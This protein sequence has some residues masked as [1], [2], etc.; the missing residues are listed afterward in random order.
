MARP[1][2]GGAAAF[3]VGN[4]GSGTLQISNG[5]QVSSTSTAGVSFSGGGTATVTTGGLW[6]SS[7]AFYV[8]DS[9]NLGVCN[10]TTGGS[11]TVTGVAISYIG[12]TATSNGTLT[13]DGSSGGSVS[14]FSTATGAFNIGYAG[15]GTLKVTNGGSVVTGATTNIG[16]AS[17][18]TGSGAATVDGT[19]STWST[20]GSSAANIA[21][22]S[23][24]PGTLTISNGGT[25]VTSG[26]A[27]A[28][29]IVGG[30][31]T[32]TINFDG[33][34]L[35]ANAADSTWIAPGS[36]AYSVN[37]KDGGATFNTQ[38]YN[39]GIGAKL[40]HGGVSATDGGITKLGTG[41][42]T[43]SGANTYTGQTI[44]NGGE[45]ELANAGAQ[46]PV[47]TNVLGAN[48]EKGKMVFDAP[49]M[50]DATFESDLTAS[51]NGGL[52]NT[53]Q[54]RSTTADT[55][56][57]LGWMDTG[58]TVT[59]MYTLY[60]D[61]DLNGTVNGQDLNTVLSNFNQT[62]MTWSQGDFNY[63]GTVN[64]TDLNAVLSNF[65]Q[66]L[67]VTSAVPEP[68]SLLLLAAGLAGLL[69][70]AWRKGFMI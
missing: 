27:S 46:S 15:N 32:M 57:G 47:F 67:S 11:I 17:V 64:G 66:H 5:G 24:A 39:M 21:I 13:V 20:T 36:G 3:E 59:V 70:Y 41:T 45:L 22:G 50:S 28:G 56:H 44:L 31:S 1:R 6:T 25:V 60:G 8:G 35:Q 12:A 69:A 42:L 14:T 19:G 9:A 51:Y 62:G 49:T 55:A 2:S 68:S 4:L 29:V 23:K 43:L 48:I 65:N 58:G 38:N 16:S 30:T 18:A 63:D 26:T 7:G 53:G 54:F 37:V 52:W 40:T 34:T 33:G 61:T 10:I